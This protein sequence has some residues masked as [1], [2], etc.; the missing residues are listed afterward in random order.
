MIE[1][2]LDPGR[3]SVATVLVQRG[4]LKVGD[5]LVAG[6]VWGRVRRLMDDRGTA[7]QSAG[8]AVPVEILGLDGTPSAGDEFHV[9]ENEARAREIADFRSRRARQGRPTVRTYPK[10]HVSRAKTA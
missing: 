9:V 4:T 1:A 2:K 6:S 5:V 10:T 7:V 8:P 3:G